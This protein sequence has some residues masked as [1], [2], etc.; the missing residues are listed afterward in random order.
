MFM[1]GVHVVR[2]AMATTRTEKRE[3]LK[4][5]LIEIA[6]RR[7]AEGGLVALRARDVAAEAGSSLGGIYTV[8]ADLDDLI[9]HVNAGTLRSLGQALEQAEGAGTDGDRLKAMARAYARFARENH[10]RWDALWTHRVADDTPL[11]DWFASDLTALLDHAVAPLAALAPELRDEALRV[12]ARTYFA[13]VHGIVSMNLQRRFLALPDDRLEPEL[14]AFVD[15]VL[16][17]AE[18]RPLRS[19]AS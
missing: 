11:P 16:A 8:F 14:D 5:R 6:G 9:R 4:E 13:A 15:V 19:G 2:G 7:I 3:A 10:N 1:N 18:A 17:G 12:R